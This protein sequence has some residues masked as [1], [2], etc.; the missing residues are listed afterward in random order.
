MRRRAFTLVELLVV[1]GIIALLI[2]VLLPVLNRARAASNS[3]YCLSSLKQMGVAIQMYAGPNKGS[4]PIAYWDGLTSP[5]IPGSS[6][7][8]YQG[9][10]DWAWLILPYLK[11]GASSTYSDGG[12]DPAGLWKL[13]KDVDTQSGNRS[14]LDGQ[15]VQTYGANQ[16]LFG[17]SPGPLTSTAYQ[18]TLNN[19]MGSLPGAADDAKKPFKFNQ[20]K[21]S[22][23]MILI[24]DA[25][26]IANQGRGV[27]SWSSDADL[28]FMQGTNYDCR[29][30]N[31]DQM[32]ARYPQGVDS[33]TNKDFRAYVNLQID[34]GPN[35]ARGNDMRF[36][37]MKNTKLNALFADGSA[38]TFT[39]KRPG[40]GGSDLQWSNLIPNDLRYKV[41]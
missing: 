21:R 36:R 41:P 34:K 4:L 18:A 25:A 23:E 3:V 11:R 9:A 10:T 2:S 37:H 29:M 6:P 20:I 32:I 15:Q 22:S 27:D 33:G 31:L 13:F 5:A 24:M 1:I 38:S 30:L 35:N 17:F 8:A 40:P 39:Y 12:Q 19:P 16:I 28:T 7:V 14:D 26:Q